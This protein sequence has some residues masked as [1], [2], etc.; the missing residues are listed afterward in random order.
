MVEFGGIFIGEDGFFGA[1]AVVETVH[2]R[3]GLAFRTSRSCR[4]GVFG[5]GLGEL[6]FLVDRRIFFVEEILHI[7]PLAYECGGAACGAGVRKRG[8]VL[9]RRGI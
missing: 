9:I 6:R 1:A 4:A 5:F 2:A 3:F 8:K 7:V